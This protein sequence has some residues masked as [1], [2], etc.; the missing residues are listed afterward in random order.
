M[1]PTGTEHPVYEVEHLLCVRRKISLT[2]EK[3]KTI[4]IFKKVVGDTKND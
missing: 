1:R 3:K 2:L 4:C